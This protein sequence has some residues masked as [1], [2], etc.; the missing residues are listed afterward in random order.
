MTGSVTLAA[1]TSS[2]RT[3]KQQ[4][5]ILPSSLLSVFPLSPSLLGES[6][7]KQRTQ[8]HWGIFLIFWEQTQGKFSVD[9]RTYS[10]QPH[11][12]GKKRLVF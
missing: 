4:Q 3:L 2:V 1:I 9:R 10:E 7:T 6:W 12:T 5:T 11:R 8:Y